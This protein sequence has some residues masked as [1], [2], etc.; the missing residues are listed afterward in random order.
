MTKP[1][2]VDTD[3]ALNTDVT[4]TSAKGTPIP[5]LNSVFDGKG[6]KMTLDISHIE[7]GVSVEVG[8]APIGL[9]YGTVKNL[10]VDGTNTSNTKY[11][12]SIA[13]D[14][15]AGSL[16]ENV[17]SY[18]NLISEISGDGTHGI[19]APSSIGLES[20]TLES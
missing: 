18:V 17:T 11:L 10:V 1:I 2:I 6:H 14:C 20:R 3:V 5:Q 13:K 8:C 12:A 9:L 19:L 15:H 7:A 4:L 16:I